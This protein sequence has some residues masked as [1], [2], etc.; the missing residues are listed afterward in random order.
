MDV[1]LDLVGTPSDDEMANIALKDS[2]EYL[3]SLPKRK[4]KDFNDY[5]KG[6]NADAVDLLK[7]MLTFDP[8]KRISV[9]K[10]LE[11]PY[12]SELH[13]PEDEP[14]RGPLSLFDF[15]FEK[16]DLNA[17]QLKDLIYEEIQL[18][19]SEEARAQYKANKQ[20]NPSGMIK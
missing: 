20:A 13:Y 6:A 3:K 17:E 9:E 15:D 7:K 14:T 12:M 16:Y 2:K 1:I 8:A 19:H 18:Y 10:A 11:H 5:F 4:G